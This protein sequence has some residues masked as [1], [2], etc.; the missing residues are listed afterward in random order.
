MRTRIATVGHVDHGKSTLIGRLLADTG[1]AQPGRE[2]KV[3]SLCDEEGRRFEFAFLLD[4]LEEEQSQGITIDVTEVPWK[5]DG[6][7][8]VFVDTPGHREFL[9]KMV[10]G[11]STVDA[12]I[13]ML[14]A[15]EG[16]RDTF[17]R[18]L[19]MLDLLGVK[20]RIVLINKM[21]LTA[22]SEEVWRERLQEVRALDP[23]A[24]VLPAAAWHGSNL[25]GRPIEMP[26]Y[27]GPCLAEALAMIKPERPSE[28]PAR[29]YIQDIYRFD[30]KRIYAGRMTSGEIQVGQT[31]E[32]QPGNARTRV[33]SI[34]VFGEKRESARQGDSIGLTLEDPLFLERGTLAYDPER[35]PLLS[36]EALAD[37]FWLGREPLK[38]G[39]TVHVKS[40][41][42][43]ARARVRS[44]EGGFEGE[45]AG[46]INMFG[47][48][49][50]HF[51]RPLAFD[52]FSEGLGTGRFVAC[53]NGEVLGGGRWVD[54]VK[55]TPLGQGKVLWLTGLSGAG[56][57]TLAREMEMNLQ[58]HGQAVIVLDG[59]V[60]REGLCRDLGFTP[61]DR[62]ENLRRAAEVAKLF[63]D[64]GF[65]VICAFISPLN[66]QRE[67]AR[68]IV[69]TERF[70]EVYV[71]AALD[72]CETRDVKGLYAKARRG[73]IRDFTGISADFEIPRNPDLHLRTDRD[74]IKESLR[75]LI[76]GVT[77]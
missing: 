40:G 60:L 62:S 51:E 24:A 35:P 77:R 14:D 57:T 5:F 65:T 11:A 34:E 1:Q 26:W 68:E 38:L 21:D 48:V 46:A 66:V 70:R 15:V 59:D 53:L 27:D 22:W 37:L 45:S 76:E 25:L 23:G 12:A 29:F 58:A 71:D 56:K 42:S 31:L 73:E 20:H 64:K 18:Q 54:Q 39:D 6:R 50:L 74:S 3:Q 61:S 67:T 16:V 75:Q 30:E 41:T 19:R 49:K 4:A 47:R 63:A 43:V 36:T 2:A 72:V 44:V 28:Q 7:E 55:E 13:L 52:R 69:G 17:R 33:R 9:K 8:Y 10:G 32:F